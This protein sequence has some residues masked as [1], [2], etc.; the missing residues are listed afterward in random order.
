M[1]SKLVEVTAKVLSAS[2]PTALDELLNGAWQFTVP[3]MLG[4]EHVE[5]EWALSTVAATD[6]YAYP[7]Y[8]AFAF[9]KYP[10]I[11]V[12]TTDYA[13]DY[14]SRP[15]AFYTVWP[16][17]STETGRPC[18]A[19]FYGREM[20]LRPIPDAVYSVTIYGKVLK[21]DVLDSD[22]VEDRDYAMAVVAQAA[23]EHAQLTGNEEVEQK[24]S[25]IFAK[26][27]DNLQTASTGR[28]RGPRA[29]GTF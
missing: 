1:R 26:H 22:G 18:A 15:G 3:G 23:I 21:N 8:F 17:A 27:F 10:R 5:G 16:T 13:L 25:A 4:G 7:S 14:Y 19:L 12:G 20:V 6:T 9:P 24:A 29:M 11:A 28:F 2:N